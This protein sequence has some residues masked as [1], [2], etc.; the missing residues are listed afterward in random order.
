MESGT[1]N[2]QGGGQKNPLLQTLEGILSGNEEI[3]EQLGAFSEVQ[4]QLLARLIEKEARLNRESSNIETLSRDIS[5]EIDKKNQENAAKLQV[6]L[7]TGVEKFQN[8]ELG[9]TEKDRTSLDKVE[10]TVRSFWQL[11]VII[12]VVSLLMSALTTFMALRFYRESVK[13]K[14]EVR[15]DILT[16]WNSQGKRLVDG[17][18]WNA[19]K[20]ERVIVQSF[21]RDN[22]S[23]GKAFVNYRKGMVSANGGK[24]IYKDIDSDKVVKE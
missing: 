17:D 9:L 8:I 10:N 7:D 20:N 11:P 16:G 2:G 12:S 3:R 13:S 19:L 15:S 23:G 5:S 4:K 24:P 22:K 1:N 21:V 18:E 6:V 14:E